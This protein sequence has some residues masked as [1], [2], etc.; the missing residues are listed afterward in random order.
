MNAPTGKAVTEKTTFSRQTSVSI[1]IKADANTVWELL[2]RAQDY[3]RWNPTIIKLEGMIALNEAIR[4]TSTIDPKRSFR[5]KVK[6]MEPASR[7]VW[8]DGKGNRTFTLQPGTGG[9]ILFSMTEKIG[10]FMFPLYAK[11]IPPFDASFEQ[12]A[13]ALKTEAEKSS[14]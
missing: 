5:L 4:L 12:F 14:R 9:E 1:I 13:L 8:G 7:M 2:T 6:V 10:G 3:P 11:Y